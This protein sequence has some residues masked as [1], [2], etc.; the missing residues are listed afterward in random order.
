VNTC[1]TCNTGNPADADKC[2]V[3][4]TAIEGAPAAD[5]STTTPDEGETAATFPE[6]DELDDVIGPSASIDAKLA[7]FDKRIGALE[8]AEAARST[9][10]VTWSSSESAPPSADAGDGV[11]GPTEPYV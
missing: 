5:V 9:I 1:T 6:G 10:A 11:A 3:C 7:E 2:R 8:A 4:G